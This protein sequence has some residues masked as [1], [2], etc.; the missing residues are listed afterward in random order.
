MK[1]I[2]FSFEG[3]GTKWV[4]DLYDLDVKI[5]L[6]IL[7]KKILKRV[8][9]FDHSYSRF[10]PDSLVWKMSNETGW[11]DLPSD[12]RK[13][14]DLY[15]KLYKITEGKFT[16]LIGD[17]ISDAGYDHL[18]SFKSGP[19]SKPKSW[20]EAIVL[21]DDRIQIKS[22]VI[23]DFGAAGKGY[24]VDLIADLLKDSGVDKFCI[25]GSGD[26]YTFGQIQKIG[27]ENPFD[28]SQVIGV[29]GLDNGSICG[30]ATNRRTWGNYHHIFDPVTGQSTIGVVATWVMACEAMLADALATCLFL[31][32]VEK[33]QE[34]DFEYLILDS[35]MNASCSKGFREGLFSGTY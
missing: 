35:Q 16:P 23:L 10:R 29:V 13:M 19:V 26:I 20:D 2:K 30:S 31:V 33:L 34:F 32:P 27:L 8:E 18:Y 15:E 14:L 17:V 7:K 11:F 3:I 1:D 21:K 25:D 6:S 24:L 28:V 5:N 22:P 12:A 4:I 9:D